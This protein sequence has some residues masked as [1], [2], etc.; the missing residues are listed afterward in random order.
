MIGG[1][2]L[3]QCI[4][5]TEIGQITIVNR[6]SI[7]VSHPKVKELIHA[8]FLNLEA[9]R[10]AF[11]NQDIAFYCLG[12]YT[13]QVP[14]EEFNKITID[15]TKAFG[16]LLKAQSANAT[17]CFLSGAGA[18]SS[19]RS[20]VLFAKAKG[21]AENFLLNLNFPQTYI[22]RPG[23]IYPVTPRQEPNFGYKV[24]RALY[25]PVSAIYPNIGIT[26]VQLAA[27]LFS[28]GLNGTTKRVLENNDI[29][30]NG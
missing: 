15:Y 3:E 18:D 7:G 6:K 17:V 22:F 11:T 12:V 30:H 5:S 1:L 19:E 20:S 26:S 24:F 13:G 9:L 8:D 25:K 2:V 29:R 21:I 23:Y 28:V 10:N 14:T 16:T 4:N 27:K